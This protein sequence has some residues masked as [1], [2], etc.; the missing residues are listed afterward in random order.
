MVSIFSL[1]HNFTTSQ[2]HQLKRQIIFRGWRHKRIFLCIS[3]NRGSAVFTAGSATEHLENIPKDLIDELLL[4]FLVFI[5]PFAD[6]A[7]DINPSA[8]S[9]GSSQLRLRVPSTEQYYAIQYGNSF[10]H[11]CLYKPRWLPVRKSPSS[12]HCQTSG[13][14]DS[15]P[16]FPTKIALLIPA[17]MSVKFNVKQKYSIFFLIL[18]HLKVIWFFEKFYKN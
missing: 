14:Q 18:H 6:A 2:L 3:W 11:P 13:S 15:L 12:L 9:S 7:F 1:T 17:A 8:P 5:F 4:P 16:R 10:L